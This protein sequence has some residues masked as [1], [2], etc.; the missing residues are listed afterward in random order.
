MHVRPSSF[1]FALGPIFAVICTTTLSGAAVLC[2]RASEHFELVGC[3]SMT[4]MA[5]HVLEF[6]LVTQSHLESPGRYVLIIRRSFDLC[7][8]RRDTDLRTGRCSDTTY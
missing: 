7:R 8:Y 4:G 2:M 6:W 3:R 5:W 1:L